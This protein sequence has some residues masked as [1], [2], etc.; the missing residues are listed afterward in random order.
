M[1]NEKRQQCP[2]HSLFV[3]HYHSER[4][5]QVTSETLNDVIADL[6]GKYDEAN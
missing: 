3:S 1:K 4:M 6:E 5:I 2:N